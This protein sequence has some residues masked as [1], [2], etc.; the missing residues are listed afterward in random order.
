M[1]FDY[2]CKECETCFEL[3]FPIGKAD[4][5]VPCLVEGCDGT[6]KRAFLSMTFQ[7]KG[8]GWAKKGARLNTEM[9]ARNERAGKRMRKEHSDGGVRLVAHDYGNGDVREVKKK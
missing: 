1:L 4:G 6:A 7:L 9:T 8:G 5:E 2:K 3:D